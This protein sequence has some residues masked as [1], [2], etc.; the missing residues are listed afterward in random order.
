MPK[1]MAILPHLPQHP[2]VMYTT[3]L[4]LG[5]YGDWLARHPEHLNNSYTCVTGGLFNEE[6]APAS[7]LAL[8]NLCESCGSQAIPLLDS[9]MQV[10]QQIHNLTEPDK[11][12]PMSQD[13]RLLV[14]EAIG[15]ILS[16]LPTT[17]SVNAMHRL[18]APIVAPLAEIGQQQS[19]SPSLFELLDVLTSLLRELRPSAGSYTGAHDHPIMLVFSQLWPQLAQLFERFYADNRLMEKVCRCCKHVLRSTGL[20]FSA[21][22]P[23]M[24]QTVTVSYQ[25]AS[26][27]CFLY[28]ASVAVGVFA[29]QPEHYD[30]MQ[31]SI[32]QLVHTSFH[33]LQGPNAFTQQPEIVEDLFN[34]F[35]RCIKHCPRFLVTAEAPLLPNCVACAISGML[36]HHHEASIAVIEFLRSF[37][38]MAH[39]IEAGEIDDPVV[40]VFREMA[41]A[42]LNQRA[43]EMLA[44]LLQGVAGGLPKSRIPKLSDVVEVT[45]KLDVQRFNHWL[46]TALQASSPQLQQVVQQTNLTG[47]LQTRDA[48]AV[49]AALWEVHDEHKRLFPS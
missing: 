47:R 22:L 28:L 10:H 23:P 18:I 35:T 20:L 6:L 44:L 49:K 25:R 39:P 2:K 3:V 33:L 11:R 29:R 34:L 27:S 31:Q 38:S 43:S 4:M 45:I 21:L 37:V 40:N 48:N 13:D 36:V 9:L 41:N 46:A 32:T 7:A 19:P 24:L 16:T 5:R 42:V 1:V 30:L 14:T 15:H 8:K 12:P 26:H 17:D